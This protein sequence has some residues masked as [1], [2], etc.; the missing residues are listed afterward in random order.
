M[1]QIYF[2]SPPPPPHTHTHTHTPHHTNTPHPPH[3]L[4]Q[5][6]PKSVTPSITPFI[7]QSLSFP[8]S[9]VLSHSNLLQQSIIP[10]ASLSISHSFSPSVTPYFSQPPFSHAIHYSFSSSHSHCLPPFSVTPSISHP[11]PLPPSLTHQSLHH[12]NYS[13]IRHYPYHSLS[14]LV[15]IF[16]SHTLLWSLPPSVTRAQ[17]LVNIYAERTG[18][19]TSYVFQ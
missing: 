10:S 6:L 4:F 7:N 19:D 16:I 18:G 15:S 13:S 11:Q 5:S 1:L 17:R 8:Q 12:S 3:F 2:S 9:L 14:V